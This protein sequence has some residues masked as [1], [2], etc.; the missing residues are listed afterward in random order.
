MGDGEGDDEPVIHPWA[1]MALRKRPKLVNIQAREEFLTRL[2]HNIRERRKPNNIGERLA[3]LGIRS[4]EEAAKPAVKN[5]IARR[6]SKEN[7]R[8]LRRL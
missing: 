6:A 1:V 5:Q 4:T 2:E 7:T 8:L 3:D